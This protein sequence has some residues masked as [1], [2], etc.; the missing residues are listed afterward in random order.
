MKSYLCLRCGEAAFVGTPRWAILRRVAESVK[1]GRNF[2]S[3]L[4]P[5]RRAKRQQE[6]VESDALLTMPF[7]YG[8]LPKAC[9]HCGHRGA[10]QHRGRGDWWEPGFAYKE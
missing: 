8:V 3:R 10:R 5:G 2:L 9:P 6:E 4:L 7:R 1:R